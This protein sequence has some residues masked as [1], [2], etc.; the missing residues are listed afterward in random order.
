MEKLSWIDYQGL[1]TFQRILYNIR[2]FLAA[3]PAFFVRIGKA[4]GRGAKAAAFAVG[5]ELK[6]VVMTLITGSW[7]TK[8]SYLRKR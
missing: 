8:L 4:I 1:G 7:R 2:R 3:I 6:D 5:R